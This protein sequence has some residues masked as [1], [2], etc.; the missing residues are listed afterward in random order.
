[1][2][3]TKKALPRRT[4][5]RGMGVTMALPLLDAMVP[6]LSALAKTPANAKLRLGFFYVANGVTMPHWRPRGEGPRLELSP[7]LGPLEPIKDQVIVVSG[8]AN[9]AANVKEVSGGPHTRC[10]AA[11]LTGAAPKRTE[12]ADIELGVSLDQF[13]AR[14]LGKE[15]ALP[16]LEL[17]VEPNYVVGNC[18]N[19]YSCVYQNTFSWKTPTTPLPME[20]NPRVVFERMFGDGSSPEARRLQMRRGRSILDWVAA[21]MNRLV[22]T[23]GPGDRAVVTEYLDAVREVEGRI[24]MAEQRGASSLESTVARP[25]G[26]PTSD[27][28]HFKLMI[29]L[30]YL[31]YRAEITRVVTYQLSREQS[32]RTYPFIGVANG[33][34]EISHHMDQPDRME[35]N[36]K[37]N[38][39]HVSLLARLAERM[40]ATPDGDGT[41]LDHAMLLYGAG[42][43][44]GD[45]HSP[46]D[47]PIL[48]AGGGCGTL[49]GGRHIKAVYDTPLM[50][51]GLS[52]LSKAGIPAERFGDS[53]GTLSDL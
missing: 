29:D 15:T 46:H 48:V 38:T 37:I 52:M 26:V 53:T 6:A 22:R 7:I 14:E 39:Y 17:A 35:L 9:S 16:S 20:N 27:D 33:H 4:F 18:D 45:V 11:W 43:G 40:R 2:I 42:M 51:L 12:A 3:V 1:M 24:Q 8:L 31:A 21:D 30:L 49:K 36:T 41:L 25:L 13:A 5:L 34:H 23:L 28:E 32:Q 47:L 10:Q 44:D 19:G 50:N